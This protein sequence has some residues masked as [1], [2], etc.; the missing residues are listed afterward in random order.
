MIRS[1][2]LLPTQ[3]TAIFS[4]K[5]SFLEI[6]LGQNFIVEG[7]SGFN[8][9]IWLG[10]T[11][12]KYNCSTICD[13]APPTNVQLLHMLVGFFTSPE[14]VSQIQVRWSLELLSLTPFRFISDIKFFHSSARLPSSPNCDEVSQ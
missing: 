5:I 10:C 4:Y 8:I 11:I 3:A 13:S 12:S 1:F 7:Q 6:L 14:D 9:L 2:F